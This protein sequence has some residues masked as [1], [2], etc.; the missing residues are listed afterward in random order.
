MFWNGNKRLIVYTAT[1]NRPEH[2]LYIGPPP[3][4]HVDYL[5]FTKDM[6]IDLPPEF[7]TRWPKLLPHEM[8]VTDYSIWIDSNISL[9]I[10]PWEVVDM[11][12]GKDFA[13][14]PHCWGHDC[15]YQ[16]ASNCFT[17][18]KDYVVAIERQMHRY[19]A[20]G[21]PDHNGLYWGKMLVRK[22]TEAVKE[23][24]EAWWHELVRG[25]HRDQLSLPYVLHKTKL[26]FTVIQRP[27]PQIFF[28]WVGKHL[29]YKSPEVLHP[30]THFL[31][32]V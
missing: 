9:M 14:L 12:D 8:L 18:R 24:N 15:I 22:H 17:F 26:P 16:E 31:G 6:L 7:S 20:E 1:V 23:F 25:S 27:S 32:E 4:S 10:D 3:R 11:L 30:K 28:W 2:P 19:L 21:Y 29:G 13:V 5:R